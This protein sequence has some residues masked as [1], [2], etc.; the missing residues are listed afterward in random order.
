MG[1]ICIPKYPMRGTDL[2]QYETFSDDFA[3]G[4]HS[5]VYWIGTTVV[6]RLEK[7]SRHLKERLKIFG[8]V[9]ERLPLL[10]D[11][12]GRMRIQIIQGTMGKNPHKKPLFCMHAQLSLCIQAT[13]VIYEVRNI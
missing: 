3:G 2:I 6:L 12:L 13:S 5:A 8:D 7:F 10:L 9:A 4:K 11:V 1:G